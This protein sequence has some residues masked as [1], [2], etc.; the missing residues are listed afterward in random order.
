MH[1]GYFSGVAR[2]LTTTGGTYLSGMVRKGPKSLILV[3]VILFTVFI[4]H[5][6]EPLSI[7][8][9]SPRGV[10]SILVLVLIPHISAQTVSVW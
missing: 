4:Y 2:A 6:P 7:Q 1:F 10:H 3:S 9:Q 8:S 5:I